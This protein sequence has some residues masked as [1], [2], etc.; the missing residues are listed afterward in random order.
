MKL[1]AC[2]TAIFFLAQ[3]SI[4]QTKPI[5]SLK[6]KLTFL[7][8]DT[9]KA[10]VLYHLSNH[11]SRIN[12]DSALAYAK[13]SLIF[14][15]AQKN[16]GGLADV[17][18]LQG[19]VYCQMG[20][21]STGF[22]H[23][24][25]ALE[26]FTTLEN[27][28]SMA[29]VYNGIGVGY[30][31]QEKY[32]PALEY[33]LKALEIYKKIASQP[34]LA[35]TYMKVGIIQY[36]TYETKKALES[37][38]KALTIAVAVKDKKNEAY[39]YNN[40]ASIYGSMGEIRKAIDVSIKAKE[41]AEETGMLP[42]QAESSLNLAQG[43]KELKKYDSALISYN[44]ALAYFI[45]TKSEE[46]LARTYSGLGELYVDQKQ[47]EKAKE[48]ITKSLQHA[49]E[50]NS[51]LITLENFLLL[52]RLYKDEG[53]YTQASYYYDTVLALKDSIHVNEK[54]STIENVKSAYE[55]DKQQYMIEELE[56]DNVLKTGQRNALA[57]A[58]LCGVLLLIGSL[59]TAFQIKK[60]NRQLKQQKK[61]LEELNAVK[62][63]FFSIL[64]HD[65]RSPLSNVIGLLSL[66]NSPGT[67][68]EE[69]KLVMFE[70]LHFNTT[71]VL[72]TM[73]NILAWGKSNM[74]NSSFEK[75]EVDVSMVATRVC[76]FL[77][78]N[79]EKK[80]IVINNYITA[81]LKVR[82]DEN[83]V[84]FV[85]RNLMSNAL[86]YSH[87]GHPIELS[88]EIVEG[89]VNIFVTDFGTGIKKDQQLKLFD[90]QQK[91]S[92]MGTNGET[93]SG[94]GLALSK[95][96]IEKHNGKLTVTS[97]LGKGTRF[98]L[99]LPLNN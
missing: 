49:S 55:L 80:G 7:L 64:S 62:N 31:M 78:G 60:K 20:D 42:T 99:S 88:A 68:T 27:E 93:G 21:F 72:E 95:E 43:Y 30:G 16:V 70:R 12:A 45:N 76:R 1:L 38:E 58:S 23:Y 59:V 26:I 33:F 39:I 10:R 9:L 11:W 61:D 2:F 94:L 89:Y 24:N 54:N 71:S 87:Q 18:Q 75:S 22:K 74:S 79:A 51:Q 17:Y 90:V 47:N 82:I 19:R 37:F 35:N 28:S 6:H 34:G 46:N 40:L 3:T 91:E 56:R 84:E 32:A 29:G 25:E 85:I 92:M 41:I 44:Q 63:R 65:L 4:G 97:D 57:F 98:K 8:S 15:K 96:F 48:A 81:P 53:N 73:D 83:Q 5:D 52:V 69:E 36:K 14:F 66:V 77:Q 50:I 67:L 86:K 13:Q